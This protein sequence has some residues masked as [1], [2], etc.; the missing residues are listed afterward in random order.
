MSPTRAGVYSIP[1]YLHVLLFG[2]ATHANATMFQG[3]D[4]CRSNAHVRIK[5]RVTNICQSQ[6]QPLDEFDGKLTGMNS[7]FDVIVFYVGNTHTSPG[8]AKRVSR[9]LPGFGSLEVL[10]ASYWMEL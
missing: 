1:S 3:S 2:I 4:H 10:L 8:F 9:Q 7:L 6:H 5:Y